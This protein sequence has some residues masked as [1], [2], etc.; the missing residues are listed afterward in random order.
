MDSKKYPYCLAPGRLRSRVSIETATT[1]TN[2][3]PNP[4]YTTLAANLPAEVLQT[5]GGEYIR[6][7]QV[8][9]GVDALVTIRYRSDVNPR[10]RVKWGTRY[11]NIESAVDPTGYKTELLMKCSEVR[12]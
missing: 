7:R 3:E 11:L 8:E 10:M 1:P 4:T 6:G 2:G 9:A 5:S 12:P